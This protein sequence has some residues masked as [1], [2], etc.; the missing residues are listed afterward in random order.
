MVRKKIK[1]KLQKS[2]NKKTNNIPDFEYDLHK[3]FR[4]RKILC[5]TCKNREK[6]ED[7]LTKKYPYVCMIYIPDEKQIKKEK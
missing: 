2:T 5:H 7:A 4:R 6:C 3:V 1:K